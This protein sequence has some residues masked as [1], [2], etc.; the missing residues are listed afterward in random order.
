MTPLEQV[1]R[2]VDGESLGEARLVGE[3]GGNR[4]HAVV[5]LLLVG[6]EEFSGFARRGALHDRTADWCGP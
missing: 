3:E 6:R 1:G 4:S 5:A 2:G